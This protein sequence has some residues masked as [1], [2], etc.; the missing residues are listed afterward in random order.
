MGRFQNVL[1][2]SERRRGRR[3]GVKVKALIDNE[4]AERHCTIHGISQS[5]A[6]IEIENGDSLQDFTLT[7][8]R[9]CRV[10]R[11]NTEGTKVGVEFLV[12]WAVNP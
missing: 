11:R 1:A 6:L 2:A 9:R 5:G 7:V 8:S 10:V 3:Y 4:G 12:P